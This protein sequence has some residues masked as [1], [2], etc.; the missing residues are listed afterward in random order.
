MKVL[1]INEEDR[2]YFQ[3]FYPRHNIVGLLEMENET[4]IILKMKKGYNGFTPSGCVR[5]CGDHFILAN[6]FCYYRIDKKTLCV[7]KSNEDK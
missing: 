2:E 5:D 1:E 4:T 3:K 6:Y 7:T